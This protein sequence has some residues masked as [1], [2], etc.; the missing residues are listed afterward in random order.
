MLFHVYGNHALYQWI[1][2]IAVLAALILLNEFSRRTK[3]GGLIMFGI[4]PAA[5]TIY[6]IVVA[7]AAG[8]GVKWALENQTYLYMNGWFHYAKLY[9]SLAGCVGFMMIKYEWGIGKKHWFKAFPFAIVAI[10]ILIA[11]VSDFESAING[12]NS[13]WLSSE[14]V[15]LYGGWHNVMNGIAGLINILCM[16]G[17]WAVYSSKDKKD[18][19]WPDMIWVYII[20]YDIWNFAYTYNCL[21]THSWFCGLALLLAPTIAALLWNKGGWIM[22]RANTLCIWCMF[23]QVFPLFQETFKDGK[24]YFPWATLTT[25]YKD[26]T[27]NNIVEGSSIN[28]NPTAMTIVSALALIVNIIAF[29]YIIYKSVKTKTNPY[30]GEIFTDFKYYKDSAAR[31]EIK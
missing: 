21:P 28:A 12:W 18:M 20:V 5:L 2:M 31:A 13:W 4:L 27:V 7:V 8:S 23:A 14:G 15:W 25:Q 11:V 26:G 9:A 29:A 19:I 6:F 22:N 17:W 10:N 1:A 30:K 24:Q 3:A 16:T